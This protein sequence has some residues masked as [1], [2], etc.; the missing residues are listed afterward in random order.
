MSQ[1]EEIKKLNF[2]QKILTVKKERS[3]LWKKLIS[4]SLARLK[5]PVGD[6][7]FYGQKIIS[8]YII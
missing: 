4:E 6:C 7:H 2:Y 3:R 8:E 5:A 1:L